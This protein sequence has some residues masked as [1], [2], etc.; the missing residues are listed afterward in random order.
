MGWSLGLRRHD[1]Q[2][3]SA[4]RAFDRVRRRGRRTFSSL[5]LR[6]WD[7]LLS[8]SLGSC[9]DALGDPVR[10]WVALTCMVARCVLVENKRNHPNGGSGEEVERNLRG[11]Q[12]KSRGGTVLAILLGRSM[13]TSYLHVMFAYCPVFWTEVWI[14]ERR[15]GEGGLWIP[16]SFLGT[17]RAVLGKAK[18]QV[19]LSVCPAICM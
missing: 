13:F 15:P 1:H 14:R 12:N 18:T 11:L 16:G 7:L 8:R 3:A 9:P 4:S 2:C 5:S 10:S 17:G 6:R 19:G